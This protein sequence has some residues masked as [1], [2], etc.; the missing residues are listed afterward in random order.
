MLCAFL[1]GLSTLIL[2]EY[3]Y[4]TWICSKRHWKYLY[5]MGPSKVPPNYTKD[6]LQFTMQIVLYYLRESYIILLWQP[7]LYVYIHE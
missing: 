3:L 2:L 1:H 4:S 5:N 6:I 7:S